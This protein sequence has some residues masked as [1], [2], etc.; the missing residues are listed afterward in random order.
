MCYYIAKVHEIE[1]LKMRCEFC[2][3]ENG[4]I[5]FFYASQ[6]QAR[7]I[8]GKGPNATYAMKKVN[9]VNKAN[10][11]HLLKELAEH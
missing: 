4:T 5:W 11:D 10:K 9:H 1:I 3:D 2:K 8:K 7:P 6:I